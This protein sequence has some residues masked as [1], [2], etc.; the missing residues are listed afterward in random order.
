MKH[1]VLL[2][3]A[4]VALAACKPAAPGPKTFLL[5]QDGHSAIV[6]DD[7]KSVS[8][9]PLPPRGSVLQGGQVVPLDELAQLTIP[10]CMC[11]RPECLKYCRP[12]VANGGYWF[13]IPGLDPRTTID[14][15]PKTGEAPT[16][17]TDPAGTPPGT[18]GTPPG[19]VTPTPGAPAPSA[20]VPPAGPR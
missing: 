13:D 4:L 3:P 1:R 20:P 9:V 15:T 11:D 10:K 16:L 17:P 14:G 12:A 19:T 5:Q 18:A 6:V 8:I 7:G 2:L